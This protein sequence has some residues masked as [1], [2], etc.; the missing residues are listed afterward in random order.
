MG[1]FAKGRQKE[2]GIPSFCDTVTE[3]VGKKSMQKGRRDFF[4][5]GRRSTSLREE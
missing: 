4:A 2:E 1:I 3:V 5:L